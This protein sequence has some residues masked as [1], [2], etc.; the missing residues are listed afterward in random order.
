MIKVLIIQRR[1][2]DYRIPVFNELAKKVDLTVIHTENRQL[3]NAQFNVLNIEMKRALFKWYRISLTR[4]ANNYD[5]VIC[6]MDYSF[7][8]FL[9]LN[10]FPR[11]YKLI[12][13]GIGVDAGYDS[14]FDERQSVA[15]VIFRMLKKADAG[16]FYTDYPVKKYI[17]MGLSPEKLF[18]A[19]NTVRVEYAGEDEK[20]SFVFL[21]SLYPQKRADILIEQYH[22]AYMKNKNIPRLIII[23]EGSARESIE[24]M[25]NNLDI[26]KMVSFTGAIFDD[27][28]LGEYFRNALLCVSPDQAG[29]SVLKSMGLGVPYVTCKNAITGGEIFNIHNGIDGILFDHFEDLEGIF[30]DAADNQEKYIKMGQAAR[31]YYEKNRTV[32]QMVRGFVEAIEYTI[33]Q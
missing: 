17:D 2:R 6:M 32:E 30:L 5:V 33:K 20:N 12:Y 16:L 7:P 28:K 29:L 9:F 14:R 15:R 8:Q 26:D 23:G 31:S 1:I 21:G 25:V 4:L 10:V 18:V 22:N 13:W 11:K 24:S 3:D 27:K 19:N